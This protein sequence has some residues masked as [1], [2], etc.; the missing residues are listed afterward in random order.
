[1]VAILGT[2][3]NK[4]SDIFVPKPKFWPRFSD[5]PDKACV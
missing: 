5:Q 2:V 1:M 3:Q 4:R